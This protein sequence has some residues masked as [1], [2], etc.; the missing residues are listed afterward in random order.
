VTGL[1]SMDREAGGRHATELHWLGA[2]EA[3]RAFAARKLSP[4]ELTQAL[5]ARIARLD[6]KLNAFIRLD[7]DAALDAA[8]AAER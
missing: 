6:P 7:A 4:V 5:L 2:A 3:T 1:D 8:R